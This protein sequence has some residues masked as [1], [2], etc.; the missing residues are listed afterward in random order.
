MTFITFQIKC[1]S[2][3]Y[4][5]WISVWMLIH[6]IVYCTLYKAFG[7]RTPQIIILTY[8][9]SIFIAVCKG[10]SLCV[11][12]PCSHRWVLCLRL[13]YSPDTAVPHQC[14]GRVL[15]IPESTETRSAVT[16]PIDNWCLSLGTTLS[17]FRP[18][19][20]HFCRP[21]T[22]KTQW[23]AFMAS[24][25]CSLFILSQRKARAIRKVKKIAVGVFLVGQ[26]D[27]SLIRCGL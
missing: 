1:F 9:V 25:N 26:F 11:N 5:F 21:F 12:I 8:S 19:L 23:K 7:I 10:Q 17:L 18:L 2:L 27:V 3:I 16:S 4:R 24:V 15:W 22:A 6:L 13:L 20:R 14:E